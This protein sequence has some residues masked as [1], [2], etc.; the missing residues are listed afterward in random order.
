MVVVNV[1]EGVVRNIELQM[2]RL[3]ILLDMLGTALAQALRIPHNNLHKCTN[4]V[5][6]R[7]GHCN[8][9]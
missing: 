1:L 4:N 5:L 7:R 2:Y 8:C 3:A 9:R 6:D